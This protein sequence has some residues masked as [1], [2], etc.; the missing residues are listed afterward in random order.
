MITL[1]YFPSLVHKSNRVKFKERYIHGKTLLEYIRGIGYETAGNRIIVNGKAE[2]NYL[3]FIDDNSEVIITPDIR[4]GSDSRTSG[5][6]I[7]A[8]GFLTSNPVMI[9]MGMTTM[10][11]ASLS[12]KTQPNYGNATAAG[13]FN[14]KS[15]T[16]SW[17]GVQTTQDVGLPLPIV[18][19][20]HKVGGN[21]INM[22]IDANKQYET[23]YQPATLASASHSGWVNTF[24][25]TNSCF[26]I[27][28]R[29]TLYPVLYNLGGA[30]YP[31]W[32]RRKNKYKIEYRV[33]GGGAY[34]V[35]GIVGGGK[36][37]TGT[38]PTIAEMAAGVQYSENSYIDVVIDGL[39]Y[40][41]YD[42]R[43]TALDWNGNTLSSVTWEDYIANT[44]YYG[45]V[46]AN[47]LS[48]LTTKTDDRVLNMLLALCEGEIESIEDIKVNDNPVVNLR[49][50]E[51]VRRFGTNGQDIISNFE[52]LE[53]LYSIEVELVKDTPY[54][55]T[56]ADSDVEGF[57]IILEMPNG[58]Y[59]YDANNNIQSWSVTYSV[60]YKIHTDPS[61]TSLGSYTINDTTRTQGT[62]IFR[63][64]GLTAGQY[65]IRVTKSSDES[66]TTHVGDLTLSQVNEIKTDDLVYPNTAL[67]GIKVL[68]TEQL[69]GGIPSVSCV[70]KGRKVSCPVVT[71]GGE[72]LGYGTYYWDP[73]TSQYKRYVDD[74]VCSWDGSTYSDQWSANPVWCLKDLLINDR[75]GLGDHIDTSLMNATEWL[76]MARHCDEAVSDG[77]EGYQPRYR[78]DIVIDGL[79]RA[80]DIISQICATFQGFVSYSGGM[81]KIMIDKAE[82]PVQVFG[83]GNIVKDSFSMGWKSIKSVPNVIEVQYM[84]KNKNYT[85][86]TIAVIDEAAL[87]AGDPVRKEQLQVF[88]TDPEYAIR[89]GRYA[90]LTGKYINRT[91]SFKTAIDA[92]ACQAGD[93][94]S[95]SHDV[96]QWGVS[97]RVVAGSSTT[98][99]KL[100]RAVT[101]V[102]GT[103]KLLVKFADDTIEERTVTDSAGTYSALNVS[104]AFSQAPA[105]YDIFAFGVSGAVVKDFRITSIKKL[106]TNECELTGTEYNSDIYDAAVLVLPT[107]KQS[108]LTLEIPKVENL[109]LTEG[110]TKTLSGDI[111]DYIDVWFTKP[112]VTGQFLKMYNS[113]K[114]YI[115]DNGGVTWAYRGETSTQH[116]R[117]IGGLRDLVTYRVS[118]VSADQSGKQGNLSA[119]PY[120]TITIVGKTAPPNNVSGFSVFQDGDY[121]VF[122]WSPN[123]DI[124][125]FGYEI[126]EGDAWD[127]AAIFA[128]EIQNN[129]YRVPIYKFGELRFMIK[130]IDTTGNMSDTESVS[131]VEITSANKIE[132]L[133]NGTADLAGGSLE[134]TE[135]GE[136]I[137]VVDDSGNNYVDASANNYIVDELEGF[138]IDHDD[139][140]LQLKYLGDKYASEG[141]YISD[142]ILLPVL[143][144]A[145]INIDI[146]YSGKAAYNIYIKTSDDNSTWTDW[147]LFTSGEYTCAYFMIKVVLTNNDTRY[148]AEILKLSYSIV[149]RYIYDNGNDLEVVQTADIL[150]TKTFRSKVN[151][152]VIAQGAKYARV[153][154]KSLTGFS[155][156]V[157]QDSDGALATGDIDWIAE[158]Y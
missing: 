45:T 157:R 127:T 94:V 149:I 48:V 41:S 153:T 106:N 28:F 81:I 29:L 126:R 67:L 130:A 137:Q 9:V 87:A 25:V 6:I 10:A 77:M 110:I 18:Y 55:Y 66:D 109:E 64:V 97:G 79:G 152:Q 23:L 146:N 69:S 132:E 31:I 32:E 61:Y 101:I 118:V 17:N 65:D 58:L 50:V 35:Y 128:T 52:D 14:E 155:V 34:T 104:V 37:M 3:I 150:F 151:L 73:D 8:I 111:E 95:V 42:I 39:A 112:N 12:K 135:L 122:N 120:E 138:V 36:H 113:A 21:I 91:A 147:F 154:A 76:A 70:V 105:A 20:E 44:Q 16:Y 46:M 100:D 80:L 96:P 98:N 90:L 144:R 123:S 53:N 5:I 51:I 13:T 92:V 59:Q 82:D 116:F 30:P 33:S 86:E 15:P 108:M 102:S 49:E 131:V 38:A 142:I 75:Y 134:S 57:E 158:G 1:K 24:T 93:I 4:D 68:A 121:L 125:L 60:E 145:R 43:I 140:I 89:A 7:T 117:I 115:S 129:A 62:K 103:Y 124:D 139:N 54:V 40:A 84:D 72:T 78:L 83:M 11:A 107:S 22:F 99:V 63:K 88:V 85:Q 26:D 143:I 133:L 156:A 47:I 136:E 2:S 141:I 114:I 27:K 71:Y 148:I 74:A 56:T 119:S 19:G